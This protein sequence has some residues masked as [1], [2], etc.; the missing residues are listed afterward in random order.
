MHVSSV[1]NINFS[2][3]KR[4]TRKIGITN[5][6]VCILNLQMYHLYCLK[7]PKQRHLQ[8]YYKSQKGTPGNSKSK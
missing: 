2:F 1:N 6:D 4:I 3:K 5:K 7:K 8:I